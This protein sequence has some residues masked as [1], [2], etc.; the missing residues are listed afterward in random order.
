MHE[1]YISRLD[2]GCKVPCDICPLLHHRLVPYIVTILEKGWFGWIR[3]NKDI[4]YRKEIIPGDFNNAKV[5]RL[6]ANEVLVLCPNP[7]ACVVAGVGPY[8]SPEQ[9]PGV[10]I[11]ILSVTGECIKKYEA[12]HRIFLPEADLLPSLLEYNAAFPKMLLEAFG[13]HDA[14][15]DP[16]KSLCRPLRGKDDMKV[17]PITIKNPCRYHKSKHA[18]GADLLPDD[19]CPDIFY[20]VYPH[21][22]SMLYASGG[23]S[24]QKTLELTHP[25]SEEEIIVK[26]EKKAR[27]P[28]LFTGLKKAA[29][30][31]FTLIFY[32]YDSLDFN[33]RFTMERSGEGKN[34]CTLK[35]DKQYYFNLSDPGYLCPASFHAIYPYLLLRN[36]GIGLPWED[37]D[38]QLVPCPDCMGAVYNI[39]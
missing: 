2:A 33:I 6:Y 10:L 5:N 25:S 18:C 11:R 29:A 36:N 26:L 19:F 15:G 34:A 31:L 3:R 1:D 39:G 12:G 16:R 17:E 38:K 13:K 28:A 27:Y 14:P 22:L 32:P 7:D 8:I 21:A 35:T 4:A 37:R 24:L 9:G 30:A 20:L 23:R